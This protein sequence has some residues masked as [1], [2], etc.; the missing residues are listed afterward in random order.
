MTDDATTD[1]AVDPELRRAIASLSPAGILIGHRLISQG[2]ES[3]LLTD[4]TKT[5]TVRTLKGRRASG[6]ARMVA[7][8][9]L[10]E[11]GREPCTLPKGP[12]GAPL[13]PEGIVGSL[14]H[15]DCVAVAALGLR[16]NA[17]AVGIDV[18]PAAMLPSDILE[19]V[20]TPLERLRIADD[21]YAGRLLFTA[22]EAVYKAVQPLDGIFLEFHDIE[23][24]LARGK[25]VTRNAHAIDLR[26]CVSTRLFVLALV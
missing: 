26:Y 11:L 10:T 4:E 24:D 12:S 2:D 8:R 13:W 7:R 21:P 9:L 22:K 3:A 18:E 14:A 25:A 6:A 16:R 1:G 15:D 20:A 17:R 23:I 5:I 19:L